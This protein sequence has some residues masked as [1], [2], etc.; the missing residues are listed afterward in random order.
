[1]TLN[2]QANT[3][4][5]GWGWD[6]EHRLEPGETKSLERD[7]ILKP[8][9]GSYTVRVQVQDAEDR[10]LLKFATATGEFQA[11]NDRLASLRIPERLRELARA[12]REE[13]PRL[14]LLA[15]TN[16]FLYY[17]DGDA[18]LEQHAPKLLD[19]RERY[20]Q[21]IRARIN[22]SYEGKVTVLLFPDAESK[23]AWTGHTGMGWAVDEMLVEIR[24]AKE[25][26]DP[27]HELV[28]VIARSLG[29]PPALFSEGLAV[30]FQEG[31]RWNG[32]HVDAW[33]RAF[34][35]AGLLWPVVRL[36]SRSEIGP[37]DT[38]PQV[39]YPQAGS[40]VKFLIDRVGL[41]K[42]LE[43]YRALGTGEA[44]ASREAG[45]AA[46]QKHFAMDPSTLE[47]EWRA[48]LKA[49]NA[50]PVPEDVLQRIKDKLKADQD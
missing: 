41:E 9:P 15:G 13:Y 27:A 5:G 47:R 30:Y 28:H 38:Q 26:V 4:S 31:Q 21:D 20:Y 3:R 29:E 50:P 43:G 25:S 7:F 33:C 37:A 48:E 46:F 24:N 22:A 34:A 10:L 23:Q 11:G 19:E 39:T 18:W 49:S 42:F 17:L 8:F 35:S 44:K 1:V 6:T 2:A 45:L 12:K 32:Y 40:I 36:G 14:R 16:V